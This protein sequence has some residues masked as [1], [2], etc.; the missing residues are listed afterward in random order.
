ML[1]SNLLEIIKTFTPAEV[2]S[3]GE[4]VASPFFNKNESVMRLYDYMRKHYPD[5]EE[6]KMEKE[7]V[8][9]KIF[10]GAE[11]NDGFM[12]TLMFNTNKLAEEFMAYTKFN[13]DSFAGEK[14]LL[15]SLEDRKLNKQFERKLKNMFDRLEKSG[16]TRNENFFY[17]KY[18]LEFINNR[19]QIKRVDSMLKLKHA[20][21]QDIGNESENLINFFML[22]LTRRYR[23]MLNRRYVYKI[24]Y[25]L[26]FL[27]EIIAH[28]KT[29][30]YD[31]IPLIE[32]QISFI[33]LMEK[34]DEEK[35]YRIVK[36]FLLKNFKIF[37]KLEAHELFVCLMN[38]INAQHV[39]NW[40]R[41]SFDV[42][43]FVL[44]NKIYSDNEEEKMNFMD[45]VSMLISAL[46]A[47]EYEWASNFV[48]KYKHKLDDSEKTNAANYG[49]A[50]LNFAKGNFSKANQYLSKVN[51]EALFY[52]IWVKNLQIRIFYEMGWLEEALSHIDNFGRFLTSNPMLNEKDVTANIAFAKFTKR[53]IGIKTKYNTKEL[54]ALSY[55]AEK[56]KY[57]NGRDWIMHKIN[58]LVKK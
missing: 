54:D 56:E 20:R 53:L 15:E 37:T 29:H 33:Q 9:T 58:E 8:F 51:F 27:D 52:K 21:Y 40:H 35:N 34:I 23:E 24:D 19:Y 4:Y 28:L 48:D 55:E 57:I 3:F 46:R 47:K 41:E 30:K 32:F 31:N 44:E 7:Y 39:A 14:F 17:K 12:R 25:S 45:F 11:Y 26:K 10:P 6:K 1:K 36:A 38:V 2:K 49:Y 13:N 43:N 50:R 18:L 16:E 22:S 5:F 42:Y